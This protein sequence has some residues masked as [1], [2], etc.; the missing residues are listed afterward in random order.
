[1]SS[2]LNDGVVSDREHLLDEEWQ[3]A[4]RLNYD[5]DEL[6]TANGTVLGACN[7][8]LNHNWI[9]DLDQFNGFN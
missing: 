2:I 4:A 3:N 7:I 1:M 6:V 8:Y 5:G 9:A